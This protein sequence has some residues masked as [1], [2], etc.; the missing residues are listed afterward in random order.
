MKKKIIQKMNKVMKREKK[1]KVTKETG[2]DIGKI[3]LSQMIDMN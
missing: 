3:K 2:K 1:K